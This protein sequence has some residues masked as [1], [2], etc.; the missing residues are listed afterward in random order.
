[1]KYGHHLMVTKHTHLYTTFKISPHLTFHYTR[2]DSQ[3][4][5]L[6][7]K[8]TI[9]LLIC[10][11][12][13]V[14]V[15]TNTVISFNQRTILSVSNYTSKYICQLTPEFPNQH[16]VYHIKKCTLNP[17]EHRSINTPTLSILIQKMYSTITLLLLKYINLNIIVMGDLQYTVISHNLP[18]EL[19][20]ISTSI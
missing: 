11:P 3:L 7:S 18:Y 15:S 16:D 20:P 14:F 19:T 4:Y 9:G 8:E 1:M 12:I 2:H 10:T 5:Q 17:I 6:I 13:I